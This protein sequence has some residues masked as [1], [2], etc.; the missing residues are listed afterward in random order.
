MA[1]RVPIAKGQKPWRDLHIYAAAA[2]AAAAA[3]G[4]A[5][6]LCIRRWR[7]QKLSD[8]TQA[9][10]SGAFVVGE[11]QSEGE[12]ILHASTPGWPHRRF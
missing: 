3:T 7:E 11:K 12:T 10:A 9:K 2:A 8:L 1:T 4:T 5:E 6:S